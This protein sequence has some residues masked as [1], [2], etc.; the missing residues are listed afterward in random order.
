MR[1]LGMEKPHN[2]QNKPTLTTNKLLTLKYFCSPTNSTKT[3][4]NPPEEHPISTIWTFEPEQPSPYTEGWKEIGWS[5]QTQN[6]RQNEEEE[7]EERWGNVTHKTCQKANLTTNWPILFYC[8]F[9]I[10]F[11]QWNSMQWLGDPHTHNSVKQ[12]LQKT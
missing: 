12:R 1:K 4:N 5:G 2:T 6:E 9:Y 8:C 3:E 10:L 7:E 11:S